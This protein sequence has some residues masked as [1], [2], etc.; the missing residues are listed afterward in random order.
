VNDNYIMVANPRHEEEALLDANGFT[1]PIQGL[2]YAENDI[3]RMSK[4]EEISF[5]KT[6]E[7]GRIT[8]KDQEKT[9]IYF[10]SILC[11]NFRRGTL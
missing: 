2:P 4:I 1:L 5:I 7:N 11:L 8:F 9:P 10:T 3:F 6:L